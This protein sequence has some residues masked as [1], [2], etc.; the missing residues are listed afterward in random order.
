MIRLKEQHWFLQTD[1]FVVTL[2][3]GFG[4]AIVVTLDSESSICA[5]FL[6]AERLWP[7]TLGLL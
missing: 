2:L 1:R 7:F 4:E 5:R 6:F 3:E